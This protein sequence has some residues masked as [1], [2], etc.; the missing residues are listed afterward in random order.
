MTVDKIFLQ[1]VEDII[2]GA[3]KKDRH[4][5][6]V[7]KFR[8]IRELPADLRGEFGEKFIVKLLTQIGKE[9]IHSQTTDASEKHWD[10]IEG[11]ITLEVKTATLGTSTSSFQHENLEKERR[12]DGIIFVDIAPNDLYITCQ[13]K[14]TINWSALHR[15][16]TGISYKWDFSLKKV[17]QNKVQSLADFTRIYTTMITQIK[18]YKQKKKAFPSK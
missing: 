9:V 6:S 16:R 11:G 15:R 10:L 18:E 13:P 14:Y 17:Q 4:G 3:R 2:A 8:A 7:G 5:W 1:L 12:C